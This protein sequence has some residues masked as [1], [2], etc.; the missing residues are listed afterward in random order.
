MNQ[1][2]SI[3]GRVHLTADQLTLLSE[4]FDDCSIRAGRP[5]ALDRA[6][7]TASFDSALPG[8]FPEAA[9][10]FRPT[11]EM[12][13]GTRKYADAVFKVFDGDGDGMIRTHQYL[14]FLAVD[15][16][17]D[18]AEKLTN[19]FRVADADDSGGLSLIEVTEM[20]ET[21]LQLPFA[22]AASLSDG[23]PDATEL[24]E[25]L[26]NQVDMDGDGNIDL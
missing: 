6:Q 26:H 2:E 1:A 25:V 17:K 7:F 24:A 16:G 23:T 18:L 14:T 5:G 12:R 11:D 21:V 13:S 9:S 10:T 15:S 8:C 20:I 4:E 3:S 19:S 22:N